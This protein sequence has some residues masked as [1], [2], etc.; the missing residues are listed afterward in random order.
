MSDCTDCRDGILNGQDSI[1]GLPI[2]SDN[3]GSETD[4]EGIQ[5]YSDCVG[6]NPALACID[7]DGAT[8]TTPVSLSDVLLLMDTKLCQVTTANCSVKVSATDPC[9]DYLI[10]KLSAGT[11]ISLTKTVVAPSNCE[12]IVIATNPGTLVWN[13]ITLPASLTVLSG[14]Q[15]P[16][17]SDKDA[18]GRVFFRGSFGFS[19]SLAIGSVI[20]I[21]SPL[22]VGSR[23]LYKRL[24]YNGRA[25][26]NGTM[27]VE[28]AIVSSGVM[29][30]KNTSNTVANVRGIVC[31]DGFN[32]DTN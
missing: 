10:N 24:T 6:I 12:K 7:T 2:C 13:N 9:C 16:Q 11:G 31:L 21:A 3:C 32:I 22:P 14:F 28:F 1:N 5:T 23:P 15:I 18:L 8:G 20:N 30:V 26:G 27:P 17:Y 19:T 25:D 29:S 4:C